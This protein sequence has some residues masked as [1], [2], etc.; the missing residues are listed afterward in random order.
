L[1]VA[2]A[3]ATPDTVTPPIPPGEDAVYWEQFTSPAG[4]VFCDLLPG[5]MGYRAGVRCDVTQPANPPPRPAACK[6]L[7]GD[8][9]E[10][11]DGAAAG[12][13]VCHPST[14]T[15]VAA[16]LPVL[17]Y[18]APWKMA[19]MTCKSAADGITCVNQRGHGFTL[20]RAAQRV[21]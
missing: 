6:Q 14:D 18:G 12:K 2:A 21:F 17:A 11:D 7:W 16:G 13:R 15:A 19:T 3:P 1:L 10:I 5:E 20:S 4:D 9:F 8:A